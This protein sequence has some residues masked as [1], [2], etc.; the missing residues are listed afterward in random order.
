MYRTEAIRQHPLYRDYALTRSWQLAGTIALELHV[1]RKLI[2]DA[3]R[4]DTGRKRGGQ[5]RP[6]YGH[7][8]PYC[9]HELV[10][11]V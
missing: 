2:R 6:R 9:A 10:I 8:C 5:P 7:V 4:W 3:V 11:E 1:T